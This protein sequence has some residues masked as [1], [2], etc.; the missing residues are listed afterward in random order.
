[1]LGFLPYR[2]RVVLLHIQVRSWVSLVL[3]RQKK[4][5][6]FLEAPSAMAA[7]LATPLSCLE[8]STLTS[9]TTVRSE[10]CDWEEWP[11]CCWLQL[12]IWS[13]GGRMNILRI[14]KIPLTCLQYRKQS[15]RDKGDNW[16]ITRCKITEVL[17]Q[18]LGGRVLTMDAN[19]SS[20][21]RL[22]MLYAVL[23]YTSL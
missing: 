18:L 9:A 15:Q 20:L 3:T 22:C 7:L 10:G 4:I 2:W 1:M 16:P 6:A 17:K 13:G 14:S 21:L 19:C 5:P 11:A 23:D 8:T 12:R